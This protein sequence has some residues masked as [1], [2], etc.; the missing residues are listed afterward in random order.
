MTITLIDPDN[1]FFRQW[2]DRTY[3][4]REAK[5]AEM[6]GE[7][8]SLGPHDR[9]RRRIILV[10]MPN[11]NP[12]APGKVL[13]IPLLQFTDETLRDEDATLGPVVAEIMADAAKAYGIPVPPPRRP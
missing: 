10:K 1:L 9:S 4:I 12:K 13:K 7:F 11:D 2:P 5:P 3:H 6:E 8:A